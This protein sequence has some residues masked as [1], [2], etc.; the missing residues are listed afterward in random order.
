MFTT[1]SERPIGF[2][3]S[4]AGGLTLMRECRA[5]LPREDFVYYADNAN[6]PYGGKD[7]ETIERLTMSAA[8]RLT[9]CGVKAI[10]LACNTATAAS[11][12]ALRARYKI[13]V[14]GLEPALKPA[15]EYARGGK[16]LA[17]LTEAAARQEKFA[18]LLEK[19]GNKNTVVAPQKDLARLIE[20]NLDAIPQPQF[21]IPHSQFPT[22]RPQPST[23][24]FQLSTSPLFPDRASHFPLLN[25]HFPILREAERILAPHLANLKAVVLGCTHYIFIRS[26]FEEIAGLGVAVFDGN[27]GAARQ[28]KRR[29]E[30]NGL[31]KMPLP[32]KIPLPRKGGGAA[33][34]AVIPASETENG[35]LKT[36]FPLK[37]GGTADGAVIPASETENGRLKTPFPLKGG[38]AADGAVIPASETENGRL[39]DRAV[40]PDGAA[41]LIPEECGTTTLLSSGTLPPSY[42]RWV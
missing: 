40:I 41:A 16:I 34:G 29:L 10:V 13:P 18:R 19:Y 8:A 32:L 37:G 12:A 31:L 33:G 30:E 20:E 25:S 4:G 36:P 7:A 27:A 17:L 26:I 6:V 39:T 9:D 22:S 28:L 15:A 1:Q 14:V 24:N 23:F 2:F 11:A 21:S 3:D 38:G 35:R 5:L 42:W